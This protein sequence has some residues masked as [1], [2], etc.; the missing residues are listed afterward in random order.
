VG[1]R[2]ILAGWSGNISNGGITVQRQAATGIKPSPCTSLDT[3]R[4]RNHSGSAPVAP[5]SAA[6]APAA[7]SESPGSRRGDS[8]GAL[9]CGSPASSAPAAPHTSSLLAASSPGHSGTPA[10]SKPMSHGCTA[11][12]MPMLRL[13]SSLQ[14]GGRERGRCGMATTSTSWRWVALLAGGNARSPARVWGDANDDGGLSRLN[15]E[16]VSDDKITRLQCSSRRDGLVVWL[17]H[18]SAGE[19]IATVQDSDKTARRGV[20]QKIVVNMDDQLPGAGAHWAVRYFHEI[21]PVWP[22]HALVPAQP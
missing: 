7:G 16:L 18:V 3:P 6:P 8:C 17:Q 21:M 11:K 4:S 13:K 12:S 10:S 19:I 14:Q 15:S 2:S 22:L 5:P 9:A 20:G 1:P